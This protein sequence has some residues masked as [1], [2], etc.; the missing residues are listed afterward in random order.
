MARVTTRGG[1]GRENTVDLRPAAH[2]F[3]AMLGPCRSR[4]EPVRP[5]GG[6][7]TVRHPVA[8]T[9]FTLIELLVVIAIIAVL[10]GLLLPALNRS[11]EEAR[12]IAC[13]NHLKQLQLCVH[14]YAVDHADTLPPNNY[15]YNLETEAPDPVAFSTNMTWCP[16]N[17]RLDLTTA[18]IERG[19]LFPYN[20]STAI[21]HC[22]SDRSYVETE[23]GRR[24]RK[25][26]TRSY[27]MSQAINGVPVEEDFYGPPSF[28]KESHI[29]RPGPAELFVFIDVHEDGILDSLFGIPPP[30]WERFLDLSWWDLPAGRHNQ[31]ASLSFADGHVERWRWAAPKIFR[32]LGQVPDSPAEWR[33]FERLRARVKPETR[34]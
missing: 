8:R 30:G 22:P 17:T 31:G 33:D 12:G 7:V 25:L 21:Y 13:R 15:V 3:P 32:E 34:F 23:E 16:G 14:L 5:R 18:N 20:R 24:L 26:R 4:S 27:N 10:V 29:D 6:A 9:G 19:L 28:Q 2:Y 11:K 1:P